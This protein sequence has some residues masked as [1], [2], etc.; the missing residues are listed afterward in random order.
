MKVL[1]IGSGG[2]EH[3]ICWALSKS[4]K[5]TKLYCAPGNAG[6]AQVAQNV[7]IAAKDFDALINF[8]K[9][10]AIDLAFCPMDE[11]LIMGIA[12]EFKDAGINFFGPSKL[13]AEIEG[14]KAYAKGFM[15]KYG[16]PTAAYA[17]FTD[18]HK[19]ID[20]AR[21]AAYPLVVKASGN[22][23]GKGVII[24]ENFEAARAAITDILVEGRY[25]VQ[26]SIVIEEFLQG[27]ECSML[28][29]CDGDKLAFWPSAKDYKRAH[30]G[31][32]G[33]M[34]GGLGI[35]SPMGK[36]TADM[37]KL[38]DERIYQP[39]IKGLQKEGRPFVGVLYF[40]L[41]LTASGPYVIE[42]NCRPGD[43]ETQALL[44]L[45][46]TDL[47]SII[48]SCLDN[49]DKLQIKWKNNSTAA[50][51]MASSGYPNEYST[52]HTISLPKPDVGIQLF[53]SGTKLEGEKL[54]TSGGRVLCVVAVD[55]DIGLARKKAYQ[56]AKSIDFNGA[57]YRN[58]I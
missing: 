13:A 6:T 38:C 7:D 35:I 1:I 9:S 29:F 37:H 27:D 16:I 39:T 47:L 45:L 23:L 32:K 44:P 58:D 3:A 18:C 22:A 50:V 20:H 49:L 2:R 40:G 10:N 15:A 36:Y 33:P 19:A 5:L 26:S 12:D 17:T 4:P 48:C 28:A 51:V 24:C 25:G 34:T 57:Y 21:G 53:H 30:D 54:V 11:P 56:T 31:D 55:D 52:G 42:Y 43:P 8:A 14:S 46:E 41:I